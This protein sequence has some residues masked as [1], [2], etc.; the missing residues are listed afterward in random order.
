M[1]RQLSTET[2][3][4]RYSSESIE[5]SGTTVVPGSSI[6]ANAL[7]LPL[8]RRS[9]STSHLKRGSPSHRDLSKSQVR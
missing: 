2:R 4:R 5:G 6:R 9:R 3:D 1:E 7:G 8:Q